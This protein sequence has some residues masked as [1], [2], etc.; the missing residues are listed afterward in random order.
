MFELQIAAVQRVS[1]QFRLSGAILCYLLLI[2]GLYYFI[3]LP[4]KS[5]MDA[6]LF[7]IVIYGVYETTNY[8]LL[9]KWK[10]EIVVIDTLWGGVLFAI[11]TSIIYKLK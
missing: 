8:T 1:L 3:I 9:K 6:F 4:K 2:L 5:V 7:G 10:P 11:V